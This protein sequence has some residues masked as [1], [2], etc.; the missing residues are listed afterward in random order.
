MTDLHDSITNEA[1]AFL[2]TRYQWDWPGLFMPK[3]QHKA[4][5]Q[6]GRIRHES[7]G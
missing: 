3:R 1:S 2:Y 6:E 4:R 5:P 7:F